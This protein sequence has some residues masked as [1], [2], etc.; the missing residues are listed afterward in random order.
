MKK[1]N[2]VSDVD[3][4]KCVTCLKRCLIL[5]LT[6]LVFDPVTMYIELIHEGIYIIDW[7]RY[8]RLSLNDNI[9]VFGSR[10]SINRAVIF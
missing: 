5:I 1:I 2:D 8:W 4:I 3:G 7:Q 10:E 9:F 6:I